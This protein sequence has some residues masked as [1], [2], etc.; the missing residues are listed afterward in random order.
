MITQSIDTSFEAEKIQISLLRKANIAKRVS[1]ARSL[2]KTAIRLSR[3]AIQR[4]NSQLSERELDLIFVA[5]HY[6]TDLADR[7]REY[8]E[9]K[10]R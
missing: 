3:R 5:L 6:G 10:V 7:L 1:I 8:F 2:S 4:A 9:R